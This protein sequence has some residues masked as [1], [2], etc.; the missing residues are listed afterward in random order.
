M[1][2][3]VTYSD[4]TYCMPQARIDR[5]IEWPYHS[6]HG[7]M[8]IRTGIYIYIYIYVPHLINENPVP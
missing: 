8:Y 2:A 4:G 3:C 7:N 6:S 5:A 1:A